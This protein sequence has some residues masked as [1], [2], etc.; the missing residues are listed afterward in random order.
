ML[1]I[2][3]LEHLFINTITMYRF[4]AILLAFGLSFPLLAQNSDLTVTVSEIKSKHQGAL[5]FML[6]QTE[7]GFPMEKEKVFKMAKVEKTADQVS[8]TFKD[9]PKGTY[10]VSVFL[11][12]NGNGTADRNMIGIPKELVGASN[13]TKLGKPTYKKSSFQMNGANKSLQLKFING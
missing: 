11:D 8:Y 7:D 13:M 2:A 10:A 5:V 9:V 4:I 3:V 12:K 1:C 6:F